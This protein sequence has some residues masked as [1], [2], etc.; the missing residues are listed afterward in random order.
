MPSVPAASGQEER[1][2]AVRAPRRAGRRDRRRSR[3]SFAAPT[4]ST[5]SVSARV[6]VHTEY[7]S[8]PPGR[9]T[10]AAA[11]E[12]LALQLGELARRRSGRTRQ[13][14]S[15]RRRSTPSPLHG[16]S[17]RTAVE[18]DASRHRQTASRRQRQA[19]TV[20]DD[21][22][23]RRRA[24]AARRV[25][26]GAHPSGVDVGRDHPAR[27]RAC[28]PRPRSPCRRARPRR[29]GHAPPAADRGPRR[30]P[31]SPGPAA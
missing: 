27:R 13:R 12:Q 16:A 10:A 22:V 11:R 14:A 2:A 9:T 1:A 19:A 3:A 6:S 23:D 20:R 24:V 18:P 31:G 4:A 5:S 15:G 8:R 30:R 29:R 17:S 25:D 21:G 26:D 7:T 28:A